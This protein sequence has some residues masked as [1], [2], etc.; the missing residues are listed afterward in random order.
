[1]GDS[2]LGDDADFPGGRG[3]VNA[4][5]S[6]FNAHG[7]PLHQLPDPEWEVGPRDVQQMFDTG[8]D[9]LLLDCRTEQEVQLA[10]IAGAVHVP[11]QDIAARLQ[12]LREHEDRPI[13]VHCHHGRRS[14]QVAVF[15]RQQ[16][17]SDVRSMAGGIELW[18]QSVDARVSRY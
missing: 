10:R 16:G 1:V 3:A 2:A 15:L 14:L 7:L 5:D 8:R 17:F 9:F 4:P 13:V 11:M 12:E 18:S 6:K